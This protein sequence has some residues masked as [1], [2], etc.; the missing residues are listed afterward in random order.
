MPRS[1]EPRPNP[2]T[3]VADMHSRGGEP[4]VWGRVIFNNVVPGEDQDQIKINQ[5]LDKQHMRVHR[6]ASQA[7][8]VGWGGRA[9]AGGGNTETPVMEQQSYQWLAVVKV[10]RCEPAPALVLCFPTRKF[11]PVEFPPGLVV[12]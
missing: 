8:S 12:P 11:T 9:V 4:P 7:T 6:Y 3:T 5:T 1:L 2:F 10:R